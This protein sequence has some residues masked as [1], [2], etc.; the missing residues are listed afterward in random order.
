MKT[1]WFSRVLHSA[2]LPPAASSFSSLPGLARR[3]PSRREST[4]ECLEAR[5]APATVYVVPISTPVD[6]THLH[7]LAAAMP[8][9]GVSGTVIVEPGAASEP[10]AVNV[11]MANLTIAGDPN[12]SGASLSQYNLNVSV[13]GVTLTNLNLGTVTESATGSALTISRSQLFS[14]VETG[15]VSGTGLNTLTHNLI[16]GFVTLGGNSGLLQPTSDLIVD[17]DFIG[18][19]P[20]VL[21]L[22]NSNSTQVTGNHFVNDGA[23]ATAILVRSGS[24][25]VLI[26]GNTVEMTGAGTPIGVT[27]QNNGGASGNVLGAK[28]LNNDLHAGTNGTGLFINVF[29]TGAFMTVQVEG[30]DFHTNKVGVD[31]NGVTAS[32]TGGGNVDIGGGANGFGTSKGANNFRGFDGVGG[33]FAIVSRNTDAGVNTQALKNIFD[34]GVNANS[35]VKDSFN[36]GGTGTIF[37]STTLDANHAYI[38]TLYHDL[39]G[40]VGDPTVGGEVDQWVAKLAP[41]TGRVKVATAIMLSDESLGRMVD[42]LYDQYL[43]RDP[44][45]LELTKYKKVL[46]TRNLASVEV[47]LLSSVEYQSR[48]NTDFAQ[49]LYI[50]LLDRPATGAELVTAYKSSG[51]KALA[52]KVTG[53]KEYRLHVSTGYLQD[54][55]HRTPTADEATAL[56]KKAGPLLNLELLV[57]TGDDYFSHG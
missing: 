21:Q 33:H 19:Q 38:Q 46:K 10:A 48:I 16:S 24:D 57:L 18:S 1:T 3:S 25:Q 55:L 31:I 12:V 43:D 54:L 47:S 53:L 45:A 8:F 17:N 41:K 35:R 36:G 7:S 27:L 51:L 28:V 50:N 44:T 40:R 26:S 22:T 32:S 34:A 30:N 49:A 52:T 13:S 39:L 42:H 23:S 4:I 6:A 11:T 5:I 9:A 37:V 2:G 15:A 20:T 29:G 56:S 14:F